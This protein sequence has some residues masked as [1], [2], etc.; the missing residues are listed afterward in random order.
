MTEN[1]ADFLRTT[2]ALDPQ[3]LISLEDELQLQ[4]L[5]L[6][7][8]QVR[9]PRRLEVTLDVP[10]DLR[11]AMIPSLITQPL[12]EN[13]I[14]YAVAQSTEPVSV[15]I[16]AR[17]IAGQL[18]LVVADSGGDA[19]HTPSKGAH[20]GLQNVIERLRMHFGEEGRFTAEANPDGGFRNVITIPLKFQK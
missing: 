20:L 14:K 2:L 19:D 15:Q 3:R 13:S 12:I 17:A 10:P 6:K 16:R 1:L 8:E 9:F 18:E 11:N 7:I 5:Y 4:S